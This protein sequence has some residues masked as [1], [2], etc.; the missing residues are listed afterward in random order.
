MR[1]FTIRV[2]FDPAGNLLSKSH[3]AQRVHRTEA[4][5]GEIE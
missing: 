1:F 4:D 2:K 3:E 5:A